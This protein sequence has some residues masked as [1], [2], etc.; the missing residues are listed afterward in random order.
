MHDLEMLRQCLT[1]DVT[2]SSCTPHFHQIGRR[3]TLK[4]KAV[5]DLSYNSLFQELNEVDAH[6]ATR[7]FRSLQIQLN[8]LP[9]PTEHLAVRHNFGNHSPLVR[10][11]HQQ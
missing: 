6:I 7:H 2:N 3:S 10:S 9:R 8:Q 1:N 4:R 11:T 5:A